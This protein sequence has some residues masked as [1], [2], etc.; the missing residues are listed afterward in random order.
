MV[1]SGCLLALIAAHV[2]L[3]NGRRVTIENGAGHQHD[4]RDGAITSVAVNWDGRGW[5]MAGVVM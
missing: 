4:I 3:L 1:V 5:S 2:G